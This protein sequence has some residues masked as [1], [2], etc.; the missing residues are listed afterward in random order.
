MKTKYKRLL[1][2]LPRIVEESGYPVTSGGYKE[3][4]AIVEKY[5]FRPT[6]QVDMYFYR[7]VIIVGERSQQV[8]TVS[9]K[10]A[11]RYSSE[12]LCGDYDEVAQR[13]LAAQQARDFMGLIQLVFEDCDK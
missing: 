8:V 5:E 7:V 11:L 6:S 10:G 4:G 2:E 1:E 13:M 3:L 9:Y 12:V